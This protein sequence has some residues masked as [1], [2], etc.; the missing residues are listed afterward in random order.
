VTEV[1]G[2]RAGGKEPMRQGIGTKPE[3]IDDGVETATK[4]LNEK[5]KL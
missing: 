5:L 1:I 2:G 3:A 4:W